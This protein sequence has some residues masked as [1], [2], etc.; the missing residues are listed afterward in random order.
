MVPLCSCFVHVPPSHRRRH[1]T[2]SLPSVIV[3]PR[4][5]AGACARLG[6]RTAAHY[7]RLV[8][9]LL[10]PCYL[11][12]STLSLLPA[13]G[14]GGGLTPTD[15]PASAYP[16]CNLIKLSYPSACW[17]MAAPSPVVDTVIMTTATANRPTHNQQ[18][19]PPPLRALPPPGSSWPHGPSVGVRRAP[20]PVMVAVL[21]P[22]VR[23]GATYTSGAKALVHPVL[24]WP[25]SLQFRHTCHAHVRCEWY[26]SRPARA[27]FL[28]TSWPLGFPGLLRCCCCAE[29]C[30][31]SR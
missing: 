4:P 31:A 16:S 27:Q 7:L 12:L 3:T 14:G 30:W 13:A 29:A 10:L 22:A 9:P 5:P 6:V 21:S 1:L 2:L 19:P 8:S 24:R 18:L 11:T 26:W 28:Q 20:L 23:A 17:C 25:A 15:H